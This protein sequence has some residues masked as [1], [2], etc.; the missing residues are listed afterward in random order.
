[1]ELK[2]E[3]K[4]YHKAISVFNFYG[5]IYFECKSNGDINKKVSI[6]EYLNKFKP[7]LKDI[8]NNFKKSV[9]CKI[10][11]TI[12]TNFMS[13]K[14]TDEERLMH[15]KSGNIEIMINYK[16]EEAFEELFQSLL[17]KYLIGLETTVEDNSFILDDVHL[18]Y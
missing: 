18:L 3:E 1:M 8:I 10:Q 5:N 14:D 12:A 13:S 16:A 4:S 15:L 9:T 11:L 6:E 17:S 2:N 7:Y